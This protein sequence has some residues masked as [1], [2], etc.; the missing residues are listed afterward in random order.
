M[1]RSEMKRRQP[2]EIDIAREVRE[3]MRLA[4]PHRVA[5]M[6]PGF[7]KETARLIC[8]QL[9]PAGLGYRESMRLLKHL[10]ALHM[11]PLARAQACGHWPWQADP[12]GSGDD[13]A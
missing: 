8:L 2:L 12:D 5:L 1:V 6:G 13:A 9:T 4:P 11:T 3:I 10:H 7:V